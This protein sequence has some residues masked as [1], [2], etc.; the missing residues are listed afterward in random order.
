MNAWGYLKIS[1]HK[2]KLGSL[3]MCLVKKS[4]NY[5]IEGAISISN[6]NFVDLD[7]AEPNNQLMVF[8]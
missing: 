6:F 3:T 5:D 8:W 7:H 1:C 2:Y 4:V